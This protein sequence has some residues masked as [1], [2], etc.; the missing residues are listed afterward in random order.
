MR[1]IDPKL[2][3]ECFAQAERLE[4]ERRKWSDPRKYMTLEELDF[5]ARHSDTMSKVETFAA[6]V[7]ERVTPEE[8]EELRK[9]YAY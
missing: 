2:I 3:P 6:M 4:E 5:W 9:H 7:W 1:T 8:W